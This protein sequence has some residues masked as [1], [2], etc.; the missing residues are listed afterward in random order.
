MTGDSGRNGGTV[1]G[2]TLA[3]ATYNQ[4]HLLRRFV[5]N[6]LRDGAGVVPLII[7]DDGSGDGTA[8][9][10]EGLPPEARISVHRLRHASVSRARNH[11][12]RNCPSPWIAFS[13]TDC[14]LDRG[15]FETLRTLPETYA[16]AGAVEGAVL[17]E[18]G[19]KPPFHHSLANARGG[20]FATANM[21]FHVATALAAGGFDEAFGNYR[22]DADLAL[23][24]IDRGCAVPFCR[25][26]IVFHPHLPRRFLGSLR[27]AYATQ[28]SVVHSE[29]RLYR[30][31]PASYARTRH[32]PD[33]ASTIRAWRRKYAGL[34]LRECVRYLFRSPGL[35]LSDR[36]RGT[37][38]AFQAMTVALVEQGCVLVVSM[39]QWRS[40]R[41]L[42]TK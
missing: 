15:Y 18:P 34:Y 1:P 2:I 41:R 21:A 8:G 9:I 30:K 10:L 20:T 23:T 31:H 32:H 28:K 37:G 6:Y 36:I 38:L 7:V 19:P 27:K 5:D 24:L 17:P 3:L 16:G 14:L 42:E 40:I 33:A 29:M 35:R 39:V 13:D 26:L 12:L 11:A 25:D 4:A 22:E